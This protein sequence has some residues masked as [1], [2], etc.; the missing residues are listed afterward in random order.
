M[1][2]YINSMFEQFRRERGAIQIVDELRAK[3]LLQI[4]YAPY[5]FAPGGYSHLLITIKDNRNLEDQVVSVI[6]EWLHLEPRFLH[7]LGDVPRPVEELIEKE[8]KELYHQDPEGVDLIRWLLDEAH[9]VKPQ[10]YFVP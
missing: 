6:H 1:V 10:K 9:K 2:Y 4:G 8:S 5:K 7:Y 3:A